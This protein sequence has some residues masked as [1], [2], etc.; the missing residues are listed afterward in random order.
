[1][2]LLTDTVL[3]IRDCGLQEFTNA[4]AVEKAATFYCS[5]LAQTHGTNFAFTGKIVEVATRESEQGTSGAVIG[6]LG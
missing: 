4:S 3:G 2:R 1:M 6:E 5:W